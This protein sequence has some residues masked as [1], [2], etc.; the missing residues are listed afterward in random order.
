M[1][2]VIVS[3]EDGASCYT[4]NKT[5]C[6]ICINFCRCYGCEEEGYWCFDCAGPMRV[7]V[8]HYAGNVK[9]PE[10]WFACVKCYDRLKN[11]EHFKILASCVL[12]AKADWTPTCDVSSCYESFCPHQDIFEGTVRTKCKKHLYERECPSKRQRVLRVE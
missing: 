7:V 3:Y 12:C 6:D 2:G 5:I 4:C 9:P 1:C 8:K 11:Y 10:R